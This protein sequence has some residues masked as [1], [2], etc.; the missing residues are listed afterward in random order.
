MAIMIMCS[1]RDVV[2]S[3]FGRPFFGVNRGSAVRGFRM[4]VESPE[5]G[6]LHTNPGDFELYM[7]G[8]FD[9]ESA[10]FTLSAQP[11]LLVRGGDLVE[12]FRAGSIK[13]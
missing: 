9:D 11:E 10:E 13:A 12:G 1:V 8:A 7:L 3:T 4:E 2:A 6:M 5:G